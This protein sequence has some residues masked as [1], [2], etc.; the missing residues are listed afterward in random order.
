MH[1]SEGASLSRWVPWEMGL[2]DGVHHR[3]AILPVVAS[4]RRTTVYQGAEYLGL[5]PYVDLERDLEDVLQLWINRNATTYVSFTAWLK[6][7]EPFKR[8]A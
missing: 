5:Y 7:K 4:D 2:A 8:S 6:G 3:V 1:A